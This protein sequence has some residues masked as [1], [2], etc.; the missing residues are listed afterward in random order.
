MSEISCPT[1]KKMPGPPPFEFRS[2]WLKVFFVRIEKIALGESLSLLH[3][4]FG[5]DLL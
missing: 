1:P 4:E 5:L 2:S 3:L